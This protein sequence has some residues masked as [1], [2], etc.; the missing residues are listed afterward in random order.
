ML[1]R[2]PAATRRMFIKNTASLTGAAICGSTAASLSGAQAPASNPSR[3]TEQIPPAL[4]PEQVDQ[5]LFD[6]PPTIRRGDMLY[7]QLGTTGA[8]VSLIGMG[9]FHIGMQKQEEESIR[10][11]RT[12]VDR[13]ITFLDNSW[14]YNEGQ[15]E[16][17]M[18]KAL[19]DG[20]R[21]KVFL[22]TK[23]D[24]RTK[25]AAAEQIDESLRRLQTDL[26]DLIQFHENIRL[27]DPDRFFAEGG[28]NEA[29]LEAKKA[30]KVR[31]I[32]FTGHKDP[33]VHLRMLDLA[34]LH[35]FHFDTCQMPINVMDNSFRSF[36]RQVLPLL[37]QEGIGPLAMKTFAD[38]FVLDEVL[39]AG[40]GTAIELLHLS[41]TRPVSV[42]ITGIDKM[43]ILDQALEAVR[44]FKRM[45]PEEAN[46]LIAR[47][48]VAAAGGKFEK[49]KTTTHFDSTAKHPEWLG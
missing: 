6:T 18:G 25:K 21:A 46:G 13:G 38:H 48:K 2:K 35:G 20:Y 43:P 5:I 44:T 27:E 23:F 8:E 49:F 47:T 30:G 3:P 22:M 33:L 26:L 15:S 29:V 31:F 24:G 36:Q 19:R 37:V 14:D 16:M 32:G 39:R 45:T 12:G 10:L 17:R 28:A 41:M 42:V 1:M 34:K 4:S 9:G 40:A 7:R 11:I